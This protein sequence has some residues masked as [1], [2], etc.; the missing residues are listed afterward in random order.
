M[1]LDVSKKQAFNV[2]I[3]RIYSGFDIRPAAI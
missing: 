2:N 3:G 1:K